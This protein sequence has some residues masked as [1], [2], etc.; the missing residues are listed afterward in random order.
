M[1]Q[2]IEYAWESSVGGWRDDSVV[3]RLAVLPDDLGSIPSIYMGLTIVSNSQFQGVTGTRHAHTLSGL[4]RHPSRQTHA[5][6]TSLQAKH[7]YISN[8]NKNFSHEWWH[9]SSIPALGRQRQ[10]DLCEFHASLAYRVSSRTARGFVERS[11]L[12]KSKSKQCFRAAKRQLELW[13]AWNLQ[14]QHR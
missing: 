5:A 4:C 10:A 9:T 13:I 12:E 11:C 2:L 14:N 7:S 3:K 1:R 6:Q 8:K